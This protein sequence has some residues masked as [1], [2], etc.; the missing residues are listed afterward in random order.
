LSVHRSPS[1]YFNPRLPNT[2]YACF[3]MDRDVPFCPLGVRFVKRGITEKKHPLNI[4]GVQSRGLKNALLCRVCSAGKQHSV[5]RGRGLGLIRLGFSVYLTQIHS[6]ASVSSADKKNM[7][8]ICYLK[9]VVCKSPLFCNPHELNF[10]LTL[11]A[12]PI[13]HTSIRQ[14]A[15]VTLFVT[16]YFARKLSAVSQLDTG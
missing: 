10:L 7:Y 9:Q 4:S 16:Y 3:P 12:H 11:L 8:S 15:P 13:L 5:H 6:P 1:R 14:P 2:K